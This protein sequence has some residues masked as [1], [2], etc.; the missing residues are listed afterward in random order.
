MLAGQPG[1][2]Q[3]ACTSPKCRVQAST[4][5]TSEVTPRCCYSLLA[6]DACWSPVVPDTCCPFTSPICSISGSSGSRA[7]AGTARCEQLLQCVP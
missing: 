7:A 1:G 6:S 2:E 3:V 5:T 4:T